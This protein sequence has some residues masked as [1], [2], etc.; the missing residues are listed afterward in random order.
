M[1]TQV[2]LARLRYT[3]I[4]DLVVLGIVLIIA[5]SGVVC[6]FKG[7]QYGQT[8]VGTALGVLTGWFGG[9]RRR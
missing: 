7:I 2:E 1:K 6:V 4:E 8:I 3:L 5:I 9:R